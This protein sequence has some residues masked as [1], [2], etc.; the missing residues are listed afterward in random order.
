MFTDNPVLDAEQ[1]RQLERL[2]KCVECGDP[3]QQTD[4][5]YIH[6]GY[7][8]DGCLE[9]LRREILLEW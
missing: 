7:I 8:C 6:G 4:A 2:P 3:I 1:D 5:L 9:D